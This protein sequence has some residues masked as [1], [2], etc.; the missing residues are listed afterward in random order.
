MPTQAKKPL[1]STSGY[2][3]FGK[4]RNG[5]DKSLSVG[6]L[7]SNIS[8][9]IFSLLPSNQ[10]TERSRFN[11]KEGKI[12]YLRGKQAKMLYRLLKK[13]QNNLNDGKEISIDAV[14]SG[15]NLIE[16]ADATHYGLPTSGVAIA[17]YMDIK[18]DKTSEDPEIFQFKN[19][20]YVHNYDHKS[21]NYSNEFI[22]SDLDYF[23]DQLHEFAKS[24]NNAQAHVIKK[25]MNYTIGRIITADMKICQ[26]LGIDVSSDHA[27]R[28]FNN[29]SSSSSSFSSQSYD[30]LEDAL[31]DLG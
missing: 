21:G 1:I 4:G 17:I 25:E 20:N 24:V 26:K 7:E 18:D 28:S 16:V 30:N 6:Y 3:Y 31:N 15:G 2:Q 22:D 8:I 10:Q 23:M 11:Y 27:S 12:V 19:D 29:N 13:A 14:P 9:G 5:E